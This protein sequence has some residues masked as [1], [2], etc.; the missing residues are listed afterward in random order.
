MSLPVSPFRWEREFWSAGYELVAGVDE[1]G[2]GA[3]AGPLVAAAVIFEIAA[4]ETRSRKAEL[5]RVVRDSKLLTRSAREAALGVIERNAC[6]IG[7]GMVECF[8]IDELGMS[9]AN[10]LV[11]ERAVF[12]LR[13]VP[14]ALLL[15]AAVTDLGMPQVG[16]IDGDARCLSISAASIVAKVARDRM[17]CD[18]HA[19]DCRYGFDQHVGYGTPEH[20][21]ALREHG[22]APFHRRSFRPVQ[23]C[24]AKQ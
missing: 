4:F 9:A 23:E 13:L 2:R 17:M 3:L 18:L 16:L 8:E 15:D 1:V 22:P 10:R 11:M 12:A 20:L 14:E 24:L 19:V 5:Q 7:M 6:A 21:R